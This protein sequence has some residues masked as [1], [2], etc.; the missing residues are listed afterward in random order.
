ME[1]LEPYRMEIQ[2]VNTL[3][4][5]MANVKRALNECKYQNK[6]VSVTVNSY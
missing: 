3:C 2:R 6:H 1:S 5:Q 4:D